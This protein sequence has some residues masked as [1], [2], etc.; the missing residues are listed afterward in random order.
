MAEVLYRSHWLLTPPVDGA[1][2][3]REL[4]NAVVARCIC[5]CA[6]IKCLK[7]IWIS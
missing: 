2:T 5:F 6:V 1:I 3:V 4:R 7:M